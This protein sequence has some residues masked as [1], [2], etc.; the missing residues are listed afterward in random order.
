MELNHLDKHII[1]YAKRRY[2]TV[3]ADNQLRDIARIIENACGI[4]GVYDYNAYISISDTFIK[5]ADY[6]M[7]SE[8]FKHL[9]SPVGVMRVR[10]ADYYY[11]SSWMLGLLILLNVEQLDL[12]EPDSKI[13]P[14]GD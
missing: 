11:A 5:V 2:K 6:P 10:K 3:N 13:W 4:D 14:I 7:K 12:G 9:F 8:F 1:L